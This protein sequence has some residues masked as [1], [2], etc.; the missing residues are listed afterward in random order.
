MS[1]LA[2]ESHRKKNRAKKQAKRRAAARKDK[3]NVTYTPARRTFIKT[4]PSTLAR[5]IHE[6]VNWLNDT[7]VEVSQEDKTHFYT[8]LWGTAPDTTLPFVA[9]PPA[10]KAMDISEFGAITILEIQARLKNDTA[11]GTDD[12]EKRHVTSQSAKEALRLLCNMILVSGTQPSVW[13][14]NRTVLILK[15]GKD[16]SKF[17]KYRPITIDLTLS[18]LYWD[19][20]DKRLKDRVSFSPRQRGFLHESGCF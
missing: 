6:K 15:Q 5:Y 1:L 9:T 4:K 3:R 13:G 10:D 16:T 20:I 7:G 17:E 14:I 18:R 8:N 11:P 19:I 2:S 12:I